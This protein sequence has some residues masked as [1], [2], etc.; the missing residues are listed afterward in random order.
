MATVAAPVRLDGAIA[1]VTGAGRGIGVEIAR[2]L[3]AEGASV[4]LSYRTSRAG[5]ED[6]AERIRVAGGA[7]IP[8]QADLTVAADAER[9]V[10][11]T[12]ETLGG[13]DILVNCAAGFGPAKSL[14]DATWE[15]V[16]REWE[17]VVSPVVHVTR[18]ALPH[19]IA[20]KRGRIVNLCATLVRRP[21]SGY[22]AHTMAKAAVLAYTRTLA[23]EVGPHGVTVNAVSP[24]MTL[25]DFTL[26]LPESVREGVAARTP[27]RRLAGPED[28]ARAVLLFCSPWADFIT[29]A[30]L[31][32]DGGLA[33]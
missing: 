19:L 3:A 33:L 10:R 30:E 9:L 7:A 13:L 14:V 24:G 6:A 11:E 31:A 32:P 8:L 2:L 25:T 20:Q 29:G 28:V 26:S 16:D 15:E 27:L 18:A 17:D 5:A 12:R 1:L 21:A 4:A 23:K 22:G